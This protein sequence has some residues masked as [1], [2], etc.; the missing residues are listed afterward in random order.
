MFSFS[1]VAVT[2]QHTLCG[3]PTSVLDGQRRYCTDDHQYAKRNDIAFQRRV[4]AWRKNSPEVLVAKRAYESALETVKEARKSG[5]ARV[6]FLQKTVNAAA[7]NY[8][9]LVELSRERQY[10]G[11]LDAERAA[12]EKERAKLKAEHAAAQAAAKERIE[13]AKAYQDQKYHAEYLDSYKETL[14][15]MK[16]DMDDEL[17][18]IRFRSERRIRETTEQYE[19]ARRMWLTEHREWLQYSLFDEPRS[20]WFDNST[21]SIPADDDDDEETQKERNDAF[22]AQMATHVAMRK[23][24][25]EDAALTNEER[26]AVAEADTEFH[27]MPYCLA[28]LNLLN[29]VQVAQSK[30]MSLSCALESERKLREMRYMTWYR[31]GVAEKR[32]KMAYYQHIRTQIENAPERV[33][34]NPIEHHVWNA[35]IIFARDLFLPDDAFEAPVFVRDPEGDID[36][37]AF[38]TDSQNVHRSGVISAV[39]AAIHRLC[40]IPCPSNQNMLIEI[41]ELLDTSVPEL[42]AVLAED[43]NLV[44]AFNY[45]YAKV[46][47]HVWGIIRSHVHREELE[48]RFIDEIRDGE[49]VCNTGK[50]TRLVNVLAGFH[51]AVGDLMSPMELFRNRIALL[52]DKPL[53]ERESAA[54]DLF[55]EFH[56]VAEEQAAWLEPLLS[57]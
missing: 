24:E 54:Q 49:D 48:S 8:A 12:R 43:Y 37:A 55:E 9:K 42:R 34:H 33:I 13:E 4:A 6:D 41:F 22:A 5:T 11:I 39:E 56:I 25:E 36:L 7:R 16:S 10:P 32:L 46:L 30:G 21:L 29:A 20:E 26:I 1:C 52:A 3:R 38:A 35:P 27:Q 14:R 45:S 28:S 23:L 40:D 15:T 17:E 18:I 19:T 2:S 53:E 50:M 51:D 31:L 44:H 57:S 47:Y